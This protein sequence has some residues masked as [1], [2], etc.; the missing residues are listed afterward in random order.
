M[1]I[2]QDTKSQLE[3]PSTVKKQ[4]ITPLMKE[5]K[6]IGMGSSRIGFRY[7]SKN[8]HFK[9]FSDGLSGIHARTKINRFSIGTFTPMKE[10]MIEDL[11]GKLQ[12]L[13]MEKN[14]F[15]NLVVKNGN[16]FWNRQSI[17]N[18]KQSKCGHYA[19]S[20]NFSKKNQIGPSL[21]TRNSA[22]ST[23][24]HQFTFLNF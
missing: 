24:C 1:F 9:A 11:M 16:T 5:V 23:I 10:A 8:H 3:A 12:F 4:S 7:T 14:P 21:F 6:P 18:R 22:S 20:G 2:V 17:T 19:R 15:K 13:L